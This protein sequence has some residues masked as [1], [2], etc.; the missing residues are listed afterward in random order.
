[1]DSYVKL[2]S[3]I[4]CLEWIVI[5]DNI[6]AQ[7]IEAMKSLKT[8]STDILAMS[9]MIDTLMDNKDATNV[10]EKI[11]VAMMDKLLDGGFMSEEKRSC[12]KLGFN[13]YR[14]SLTVFKQ[15]D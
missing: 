11:A 6:R 10:K 4:K 3:V 1:M 7:A 5:P 2:D 14:Y 9:F 13:D 15:N 8:Y 12:P